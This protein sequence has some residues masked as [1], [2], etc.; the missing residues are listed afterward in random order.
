V[1]REKLY[2]ECKLEVKG[3]EHKVEVP[4]N[5]LSPQLPARPDQEVKL[6]LGFPPIRLVQYLPWAKLKQSLVGDQGPFA[7]PAMII[8]ITGPELSYQRGLAVNDPVRNR[9]TSLIGFWKYFAASDQ[10]DRDRLFKEYENELTRD[11]RLIVGRLDMG[12]AAEIPAEVGST[13][14]L[15]DLGCTI[16]IKAFYPTFVAG[17]NAPPESTSKPVKRLNPAVRLEI[18]WDGNKEEWLVFSRFPEF[19]RTGEKKA[20]YTVRLDCPYEHRQRVPHFALVT[21]GKK[22][23]EVWTRVGGKTTSRPLGPED[24]VPIPGSKYTFRLSSFSPEARIKEDYE[25]TKGKLGSTVLKAR[26]TGIQ[27]EPTTIWLR[28]ARPRTVHTKVGPMHLLFGK[29]V[30]RTQQPSMPHGH[31]GKR[32]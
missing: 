1:S 32:P 21:I 18:E 27:G 14:V 16:R 8:D 23:H 31:G 19:N 24:K 11:P 6:P 5:L 4:I 2:F 26:T 29:R 30:P 12:A 22:R 9:M 17:Q 3:K 7:G 13:Q 20:P 10:K 15:K 28:Y 25:L